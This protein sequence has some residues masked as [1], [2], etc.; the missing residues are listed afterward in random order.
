VATGLGSPGAHLLASATPNPFNTSIELGY[1][2]PEAG[3]LRLRVYSVTGREVVGL[4]DEV[5][6]AGEYSVRWD[7]RDRE[8]RLLPAG[9]YFAQLELGDRIESQKLVLAR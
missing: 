4:V 7:G 6:N 2:L 5:Q 3:R 9:V 1:S 8:G